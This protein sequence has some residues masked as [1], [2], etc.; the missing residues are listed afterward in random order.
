MCE[1][2]GQARN[3]GMLNQVQHDFVRNDGRLF[4]GFLDALDDVG[5]I[6]IGHAGAGRE[7]HADFEEV[8]LNAVGIDG[9]IGIDGLLVHR[10]KMLRIF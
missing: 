7:A 2:P 9:G 6:F 8:D 5:D 4:Y 3:D 10:V 1:I